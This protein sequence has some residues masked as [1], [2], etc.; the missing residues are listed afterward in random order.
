L[1]VVPELDP[2]TWLPNQEL[3]RAR[4]AHRLAA[5]QPQRVALLHIDL[6]RFRD[7]NDLLGHDA[8]DLVLREAAARIARAFPR[9]LL[10]HLGGDDFAALIEAAELGQAAKLARALLDACR[11]PFVVDCLA[12]R[13]TASVGIAVPS[14]RVPDAAGLIAHAC[15]ALYRAKVAG[16]DRCYPGRAPQA[17]LP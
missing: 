4:L 2:L 3:F 12:L 15:Y 10:G 16:R 14:G 13:I 5:G 6:D 9:A 17:Q 8:G 11:E 7:V 1:R